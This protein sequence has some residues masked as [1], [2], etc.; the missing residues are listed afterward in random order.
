M[1]SAARDQALFEEWQRKTY[2]E[3][4]K[5]RS[6]READES[7]FSQEEFLKETEEPSADK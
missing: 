5:E 2:G 7:K 6:R 4:G 1:R 3:T